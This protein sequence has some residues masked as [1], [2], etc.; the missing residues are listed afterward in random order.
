MF[1]RGWRVAG[2]VLLAATTVGCA[3]PSREQ[4]AVTHDG[5]FTLVIRSP[6]SVW[7]A[8]DAIEIEAT[9]TYTGSQPEVTFVGSGS[10]V[11]FFSVDE[12][13]GDRRMDAAWHDDCRIYSIG[14]R[15]PITSPYRKSAGFGDEDPNA[16]FYRAFFKDPVFH[17]PPGVWTIT[18]IANFRTGADCGGGR[19]V[20][21]EAPLTINVR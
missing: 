5:E 14:P 8:A 1:A 3:E 2:C 13:N 6:A 18:A 19:A 9:L 7:T 16:A 15:D 12:L 10:G 20:M 17:L 21:L 11:L 4:R